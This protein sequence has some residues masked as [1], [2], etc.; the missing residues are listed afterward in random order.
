MRTRVRAHAA[1][2]A[3]AYNDRAR[4]RRFR[5][6]VFSEKYIIASARPPLSAEEKHGEHIGGV[7]TCINEQSV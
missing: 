1:T 6:V 2:T 5:T 4:A 7:R 3:T